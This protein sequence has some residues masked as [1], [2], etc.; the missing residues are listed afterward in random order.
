MEEINNS[1]KE[2]DIIYSKLSSIPVSGNHV[3]T[4]AEIRIR[5][6]ALFKTIGDIRSSR[7]SEK[8]SENKNSENGAD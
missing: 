3:E 7:S 4:M 2:L 8:C 5:L 6:R 1:Q